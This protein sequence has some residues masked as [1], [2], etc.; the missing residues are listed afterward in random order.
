VM[1][2]CFMLSYDPVVKIRF[3]LVARQK[4]SWNV[5][6][7]PFLVVSQ[8]SLDL[9]SEPLT[10]QRHHSELPDLNQSLYPL[11]LQCFA[12]LAFCHTWPDFARLRQF[13]GWWPL[14]APSRS[15]FPMLSLPLFNSSA[16]FY[17][18][19]YVGR[20]LLTKYIH[21]VFMDFLRGHPSLTDG[22]TFS[23]WSKWHTPLLIKVCFML[24]ILCKIACNSGNYLQ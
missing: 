5:K 8:L 23:I 7:G 18:A 15:S 12:G 1:D 17:S 14:L 2:P 16:H 11:R 22:S 13:H 19:I 3:I 4:I 21:E 6:L 9:S 24:L 10:C 20:R